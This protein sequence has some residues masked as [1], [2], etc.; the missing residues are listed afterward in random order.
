MF[1]FLSATR[2]VV[3]VNILIQISGIFSMQAFLLIQ[4]L[5]A[6]FASQIVIMELLENSESLE[7]VEL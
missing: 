2:I 4:S 1:L 3:F 7:S 5:L 6:N